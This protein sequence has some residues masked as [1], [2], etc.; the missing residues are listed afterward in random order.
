MKVNKMGTKDCTLYDCTYKECPE[1]ANLDREKKVH[2]WLL[3]AE[4]GAWKGWG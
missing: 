3:R 1:Q 2:Q 4:G